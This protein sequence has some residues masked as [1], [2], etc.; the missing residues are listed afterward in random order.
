[1]LTKIIYFISNHYRIFSICIVLLFLAAL[2]VILT[3]LTVDNSI[4]IWYSEDDEQ[5]QAFI[6]SQEKYGN[7]DIVTIFPPYS[8]EVYEKQAVADLLRLEDTLVNLDYVDRVYIHLKTWP[9]EIYSN[10]TYVRIPGSSGSDIPYGGS[11]DRF[12]WFPKNTTGFRKN[13]SKQKNFW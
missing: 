12:V 11:E 1:V 8:F 5:Y 7:D 4:K 3:E 2:G 13:L 6:D 9:N 10:I